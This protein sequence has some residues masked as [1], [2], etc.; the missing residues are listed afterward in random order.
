MNLENDTARMLTSAIHTKG[1]WNFKYGKLEVRLRTN[2]LEGNFPAVW[3]MPVNPGNPY[4]YGEIDI[5]ESF[6]KE[7]KAYQTVHSHRSFMLQ[8]QDGQN[9][10]CKKLDITKWHIYGIE[11]E[12]TRIIFTI[13]G[14]VTGIYM[15][16]DDKTKLSE[17]QWSFDRNFYIIMNQSVGNDSW[18]TPNYKS[19]YETQIDWIRVYQ[20]E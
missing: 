4:S 13:D 14:K 18:H 9:S 1:K 8:K 16:S 7:G 10:F 20:L 3:L 12:S 19:T 6:G 11:W 17:G 5:F 2:N 15:K